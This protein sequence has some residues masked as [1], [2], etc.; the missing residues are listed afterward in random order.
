MKEETKKY[1]VK[2]KELMK[3]AFEGK[4]FSPSVSETN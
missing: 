1:V 3:V 4:I 2:L